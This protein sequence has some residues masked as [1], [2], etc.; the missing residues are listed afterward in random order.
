M[1]ITRLGAPAV[2]DKLPSLVRAV[3]AAGRN[4]AWMCDP[5]HGNSRALSN[6]RKT[7]PFDDVLV[8]LQKSFEVHRAAGTVLAGVHFELTGE[9]VTECTGGALELAEADL[10]TN[11][12]TFCDPRLNYS[13]SMEMA[14]LISRFLREDRLS[15]GR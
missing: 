3:E 12:Q 15:P 2:T 10:A 1:L 8:E 4:V 9:D 7:R 14:F 5:M 13:Q 6:G 11:Y